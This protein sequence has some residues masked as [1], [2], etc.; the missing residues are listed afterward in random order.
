ML[1]L[2]QID[3]NITSILMTYIILF[4]SDFVQLENKKAIE[5]IQFHYLKLL[6]HY[7][8]TNQT[9]WDQP[10]QTKLAN[11]LNAVTCLREMADIKKARL[12]NHSAYKHYTK[13]A[14]VNFC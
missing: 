10:P 7:I 6:E 11:V 5:K 12:V 8:Y 13:E 14:G 1:F 9:N 4:S 2:S 3:D